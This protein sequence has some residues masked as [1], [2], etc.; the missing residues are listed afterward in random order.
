MR[1]AYLI[2][3]HTDFKILEKILL[4]LDFEY[5]DIYI[6]ID[7]KVKSFDFDFY[8]NL[9][10]K[11]SIYFV[12]RIDVRWA[13]YKQ[14]MCEY[15]LFKAAYEKHYDYYHLISGVDLPLVSHEKI[16]NF[17]H[18]NNGKEFV[19]FD[20]HNKINDNSIDR[21]KYYHFFVGYARSNNKFLKKLYGFCN[22]RG[23]S[24][25]KKLGINRIKKIPFKLRKGANWVS[26]TDNFVKY[27][28]DN[29]KIIKKYFKYSYCADEL[30]V[31][32]LLYNSDFYDNVF[33]MKNND[34]VGIKRCIDWNRGEPYTYKIDDLQ[35]LL[36]SNCFWARKFSTK[37][38]KKIIDVIYNHVL[39]EKK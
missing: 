11:S 37:V 22:Y 4:L 19:L 36:N 21:I 23:I 20:D 27:I 17:F 7:K 15:I 35:F 12:K 6:H 14:I 1:H 16:Y 10:K 9:V 34:Y 32:T 24:F 39:E 18:E 38:D 31:Q 30:L 29:E 33:S 28:L 13:S 2:M 5:N 3:A 8:R 26:V 25:Q